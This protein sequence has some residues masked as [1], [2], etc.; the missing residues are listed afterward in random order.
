MCEPG[1]E[2]EVLREHQFTISLVVSGDCSSVSISDAKGR[3]GGHA[4]GRNGADN[5]NAF[6]VQWKND[7]DSPCTLIFFEWTVD[8][9]G[10][11]VEIPVWPFRQEPEGYIQPNR[12]YIAAANQPSALTLRRVTQRTIIKYEVLVGANVDEP[13][14]TLDPM[15]VVER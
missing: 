8:R 2:L 7:T 10:K 9:D 6:P 3:K 15:I 12:L 13:V 4:R 5:A 14:A 11:P 1:D